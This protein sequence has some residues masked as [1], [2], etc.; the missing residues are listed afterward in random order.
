MKDPRFEWTRD[1]ML[2]LREVTHDDEGLYAIKLVSGFTYE[3]VRLIV[4]GPTFFLFYEVQ[5]YFQNTSLI[6]RVLSG[7]E[8]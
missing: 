8:L 6:K 3:A 4:S 2:V 1:R 7:P 5:P